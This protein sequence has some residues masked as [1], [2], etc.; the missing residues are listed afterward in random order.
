[1]TNKIL[2]LLVILSFSI[3]FYSCSTDEK[4]SD[5]NGDSDVVDTVEQTQDGDEDVVELEERNEEV[6]ENEMEDSDVVDTMEESEPEVEVADGDTPSEE[7]DEETNMCAFP[8]GSDKCPSCGKICS[9]DRDCPPGYTCWM[10][11]CTRECIPDTGDTVINDCGEGFGCHRAA[12]RIQGVYYL[13]T[14]YCVRGS[15]TDCESDTECREKDEVCRNTWPNDDLDEIVTMCSP[16]LPCAA[17]VGEPCSGE[18]LC[19]TD[20][21]LPNIYQQET[22]FCSAVCSD[23]SQCPEG[24]QCR[25][26]YLFQF[27]EDFPRIYESFCVPRN[28]G[29]PPGEEHKLCYRDDQCESL[30]MECIGVIMGLDKD[31]FGTFKRVCASRTEGGAKIGEACPADGVCATQMCVDDTCTRPCRAVDGLGLGLYNECPA[32]MMCKQHEFVLSSDKKPKLEICQKLEGSMEPCASDDECS[33]GEVCG[34]L[35]PT[36]DNLYEGHCISPVGEKEFGEQCHPSGTNPAFTCKN[37]L[38]LKDDRVCTKLCDPTDANSCPD[39]WGCVA[40]DPRSDGVLAYVCKPG[41]SSSD[42]DAEMDEEEA[43]MEQESAIETEE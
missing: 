9:D 32:P 11:E 17:E 13:N 25:D 10:G 8:V 21:C 31:E 42:G 33:N 3:A 28:F 16:K 24:M 40:E 19:E 12:Y 18:N 38:C 22:N 6:V 29:L 4:K 1:M 23:D 34:A 15:G 35:S 37:N 30:G 5:T 27:I 2:Y 26:L 36:E 7:T 43:G 14:Y 39:G 20:W 41:A